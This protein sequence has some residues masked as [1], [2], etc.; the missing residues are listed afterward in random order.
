[1]KPIDVLK[2]I[3]DDRC[4]DCGGPPASAMSRRAFLRRAAILSASG[5]VLVSPHAWAAK[6]ADTGNRRR[7]VVVFLRGAVDGLNVV[8]PHGE[9]A[10]Y[11]ARPTISVGRAG[12]GGGAIDLDGYFGLH[13]ALAPLEGQWHDGTLAFVHACGSPDPT[14]SHFDAQD[15]MESG[16]PGVK[17]TTDGWLNRTLAA[18]PGAHAPT[19]AL[20]LGA[21]VPRILSGKEPVA[22]MP[23][24][25]GAAQPMPMDRPGIEK[26][27]DRLYSG[28]DPISR[29]YRE[30][31]EARERLM[32]ELAL[33]MA[34]ANA[35]APSPEGFSNDTDRIARLMVRDSTIRVGFMALG[36]WD[37]HINQ[38]AA[39]GQLASHLRPLAQGLAEFAKALGS[40]YNDTVIVV[41]SEFG[42]TLH[43]NGNGGTD[44]GHGN[45]MWLM[46]GPIRGGA[47]YGRW[48]GLHRENLYQERDLA[49]TTDFR[50]PLAIVLKSHFQLND[51][52]I[53]TVF[54]S[55]P[56]ST[57]NLAGI[58]KL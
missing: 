41:I 50:E 32:H 48:P 33:D 58:V 44:H 47:V 13:P 36:G 55:M 57:G 15:F 22:N 26:V 37:T 12:G 18:M 43:E 46:G 1:M 10:Y 34:A 19:E 53:A 40:N 9:P 28:D 2:P 21:T 35:G 25:R 14:R 38:G 17:S 16:T 4:F 5:I 29:T 6:T 31:R 39:G 11:D 49:V 27:F 52:Q 54:P 24:G 30:G 51:A 20:S 23:I 42:R 3:A 56:S 7:L 45:V 8:V